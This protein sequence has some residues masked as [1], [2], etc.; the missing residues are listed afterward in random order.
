MRYQDQNGKFHEVNTDERDDLSELLQ[1][2]IDHLD[3]ILCLDRV[4]DIRSICSK[5]EF[6]KRYKAQSPSAQSGNEVS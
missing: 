1:H 6:A 2:E 3:G 4:T 5:E